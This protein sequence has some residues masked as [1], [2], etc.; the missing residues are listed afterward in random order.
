MDDFLARL[1]DQEQQR[2]QKTH[3]LRER[4]VNPYPLRVSR[5]H[6][7]RQAI[8][9]F[10][11]GETLQ[12]VQ[13]VGRLVALRDMGK[14]AFAHIQDGSAKIQLMFR[15]D[16][17][18][19]D[20]Y[21]TLIKDFDL[22][23]FIGAEG[24][25]VRTKTGEITLQVSRFELLAKTLSPLPEKWHGLKDIE[26]RYRQRYLD[27][28]SNEQAREIFA[29]RS[30]IVTAMRKY[31][32][33]HSFLEVETPVLQPLY[34]GGAA[35]PFVTHH[36]KLDQDMYLR[37]ADELYLKRLLVGGLERVYE[38]SKDFRNEGV[39]FKH[40]PEFTMMECYQAYG[41]YTTMMALVEELYAACSLAAN[42]T[43]QIT[44]Q[45]NAI[46]LTPPW[47]RATMRDLI[48]KTSGVDIYADTDLPSLRQRIAELNLKVE[49]KPTWGKQV[50]ELFSAFAEPTLIQPTFVM[51]YPEEI[52]PFAKKKPDNPRVVERFEAFALNM[53]LGNAFT[54]LNDPLDQYARFVEQ[55]AQRD[56][57][58]KE[59]HP[60]D[61][62][63]IEAL[64]HGMP[65][66][67]GL[68]IGVDRMVMLLTDQASIREV[69][70]FPQL[71][72]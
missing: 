4:G 20:N 33:E 29:K 3:R 53:E 38:I 2:Y 32:D 11:R 72:S 8:D 16:A 42:G 25:I 62:D 57:G 31:L 40:N 22:G 30:K 17:V 24:E 59:A 71:R 68:G 58:D 39:D 50:D 35:E 36:N 26:T 64:M 7:A 46:D 6:T 43:L 51:D 12:G 61:L 1:N 23:D 49:A 52:S 44:Y 15:K 14:L 45:G 19:A 56:A 55:S 9:A 70:L 65:P 60:I 34:G 69:I 37:I 13:L 67:G 41:D 63:F 18:G 47:P 27:L 48:L 21:A 5:T 54:E 10:T 28:L 66:T